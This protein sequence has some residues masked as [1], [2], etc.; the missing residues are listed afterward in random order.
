MSIGFLKK[1]SASCGHG[2]MIGRFDV[3]HDDEV[4]AGVGRR[5][6]HFGLSSF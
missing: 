6:F 5:G 3:Q 2:G 4:W 1:D